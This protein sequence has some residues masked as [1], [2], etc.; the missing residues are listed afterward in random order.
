MVTKLSKS[1]KAIKNSIRTED[2]HILHMG[3]CMQGELL[4]LLIA[5][6]NKDYENI[7]EEVGDFCFYFQGSLTFFKLHSVEQLI[8]QDHC[9]NNFIT[10]E[11]KF[12]KLHSVEQLI[13]QDHC[14]NNFITEEGKFLSSFEKAVEHYCD[15]IKKYIFYKKELPNYKYLFALTQFI[16]YKLQLKLNT[17]SNITIINCLEANMKKLAIRFGE[18][19]DYSNQAAIDRKDKK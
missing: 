1:P 18:N 10:E 16:Y 4:E 19:Y 2:F 15:I 12:F 13:Y 17:V 6:E 11:G 14:K 5:I 9:K 8:Y 7:I 3:Y